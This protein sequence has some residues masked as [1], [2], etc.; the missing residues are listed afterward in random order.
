MFLPTNADE[1]RQLGWDA[2]DAIL[3]SGDAYVDSPYS[4]TAVIGQVLLKAGFRVGGLSQPPVGDP[5]AFRIF[6]P[7]RLFWGIS[8]G[9]V[10]S[11]V[12][13]YT[14]SGK[15]RRQDDFTPGGV[16]NRRPDR[17][18]IV[19]A[20]LARAAFRPARPIILGG[21][22]AS[23]RRVAHYDFWSD[24]VRRP[25][26][27]DAKADALCY[28]MG[29]RAMV[30][31]A[32]A[33]RDGKDWR[34]I[35]GLCYLA[36]EADV[37]ARTLATAVRLPSFAEVSA[38]TEDGRR[39]FL[40][41]FNLFAAE[42][43]AVTARP[44]LQK[45]DTR[46]LVHNPPAFP[47]EQNELD[48]VHDIPYMLDAPPSI[49]AQ[50]AIRALDT[51]RFSVTTHRGCYGNCRFCAI[52]VHQGRRV[53]S[54]SPDSI[55]NEVARFARHPSFR[56]TVADVGGPTANMYAIDCAR[57]EENGACPHKNC[58]FPSVCPALKPDHSAQLALLKRLRS[59]S[60]VKHVFVA[61]G[62]RPDLIDADS[63]HGCDYVEA[64][65][66]HHVSGQLKLAPEHVVDHVLVAMGKPDIAPLLRFKDRF[67]T[68]SRRCG[69][70][71]FLTYYF[72]AAHPGCTERDMRTLK[73]FAQ[74]RLNL[75]PEQVQIFT[76]TPLTA[77]TTMYYTGLDPATGR[78]VFC[79]RSFRDRQR[80]KD[81][82]VV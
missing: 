82:V 6:G 13:N 32:E 65:A 35:R 7:P 28:G 29:E 19:Y 50:G 72:I 34:A 4:G 55:V 45:T 21:I 79:A 11:M 5:A 14:A 61:S 78:P 57:K 67:D 52:A 58:L 20:N 25:V 77:S 12:A 1:M 71:Q 62:L 59:L 73:R 3:V 51:I 9:C 49:S 30:A 2:L 17:A 60:G 16:N 37:P 53:V 63:I 47:L 41:A 69:K 56:G 38:P 76:P 23:L 70:R 66:Q 31:F 75:H 40:V 64:L 27:C 43:D 81:A 15:K 54:R 42:Q 26:I 8:A 39:A 44:L 48:A 33:L 24:K 68:A 18:T 80:Q 74:T 22:E 46:F 36:A 10:D